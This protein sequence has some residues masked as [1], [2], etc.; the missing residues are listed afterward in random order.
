MDNVLKFSDIS[1][2]VQTHLHKVYTTLTSML[3]LSAAGVSMAHV[4]SLGTWLPAIGFMACVF[5]LM[6]LQPIAKNLNKRYGLLAGC[7]L[8]QGAT[9]GPLVNAVLDTHPGVLAAAFVGTSAVFACFS[10][11]ALMSR[12]RSWLYLGGT[13][14]S[15]LST[16]MVLRLGSYF[17]GGRAFVLQAELYG[18]LLVF[19]GYVLFDTQMI[20]EKAE[21]GDTD[22]IKHAL[23]LFVDFVA[24]FVRLLVIMLQ[25]AE[26]RE[27]KRGSKNR[28]R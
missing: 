13:L 27:E 15:A 12:K 17:L 7:A 14:S 11:A 2:H 23:D 25:N 19:V 28:R 22:H 5:L 1:P 6:T 10:L 21:L 18:G 4:V 20:V 16:F 24:I 26:K 8:C 3:V 9:L